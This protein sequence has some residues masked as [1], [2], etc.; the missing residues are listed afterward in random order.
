MCFVCE[1]IGLARSRLR[2][3]WRRRGT[4][5]L[6]DQLQK[7]V[8]SRGDNVY[9]FRSQALELRRVQPSKNNRLH[10][11]CSRRVTG[12]KLDEKLAMGL[13]G[14]LLQWLVQDDETRMQTAL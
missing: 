13:V 7:M 14:I 8:T 10:L 12:E 4:I 11:Q 9:V 3:I 6:R 1:I 5:R 2:R